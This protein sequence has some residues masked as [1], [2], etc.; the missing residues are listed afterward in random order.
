MFVDCHSQNADDPP[1]AHDPSKGIDH[2]SR[3]GSLEEPLPPAAAE[4]ASSS[5]QPKQL[6]DD[7]LSDIEQKTSYYAADEDIE[8][9]QR[10][11]GRALGGYGFQ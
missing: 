3:R 11:V 9:I 2:Q 1:D 10:E 6:Q 8:E 7:R 5:E 4:V